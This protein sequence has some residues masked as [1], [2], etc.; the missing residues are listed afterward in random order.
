MSFGANFGC[1]TNP[2][3]QSQ[4]II[5]FEYAQ[6]AMLK[7]FEQPLWKFTEKF[8]ERGRRMRKACKYIDD[9]IYNM[10]N[11]YKSELELE[12]VEEKSARNLLALL[13]NAVDDN[14]KKLNDKEL[15]DVVLNVIL[16]GRDTTAQALSWMMYLIMANQPVEDLLLQ[17]INTLLSPEMSVPSYDDH[18]LYKYTLATF[19]E[20]LRL[21]PIMCIKDNVLPN[22]T[23][24]FAG[25][26]IEYNLYTMGRDEKIWGE[27]AKQFNPQR[28]LD[29]E[30]GLRPNQ[31]KFA[32][33]HAGPRICLGQQLATLEV[34]MLV[35]MMLRE[36]KFELVPGQKS[37]PEFF[38]FVLD[39]AKQSRMGGFC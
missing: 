14:G 30:D 31:F 21:Y 19:Y 22:N 39:L 15:R 37:P 34:I 3:E 38:V 13:I 26:Y 20:T 9:Y 2:E 8:S 12:Q 10:I 6:N 4:F 17:E 32:S 16:A 27:D 24:V 7:R 25:E 1:L 35:A 29:S 28:F 33:F 18:K 11:D 5:N 36:F 23:P